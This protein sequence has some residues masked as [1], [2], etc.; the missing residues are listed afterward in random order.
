VPTGSD[1][2]FRLHWTAQQPVEEPVFGIA[3]HT[4]DGVHVTGPNTRDVDLSTGTVSGEGCTDLRVPRLLLT[5]GTY[6]LTAAVF[7]RGVVHAYD[8]RERVLRFDVAPGQPSDRFGVMSF[9][10]SWELG[11]GTGSTP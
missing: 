9:G 1:V 8:H 6:E 11:P 5:P 10:G 3:V 7:D 2:T 4:L